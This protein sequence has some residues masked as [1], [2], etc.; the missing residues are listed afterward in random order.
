MKSPNYGNIS[1]WIAAI[2]CLILLVPTLAASD[3]N[4]ERY[5]LAQNIY[6]ESAN[7]PFAGTRSN[8]RDPARDQCEG[9][10]HPARVPKNGFA[11]A[12]SRCGGAGAECADCVGSGS[13]PLPDTTEI[14]DRAAHSS[15]SHRHPQRADHGFQRRAG[16]AEPHT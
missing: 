10:G 6:F 7:Q 8:C 14:L 13:Q 2:V 15:E 16:K 9:L 4:G 11:T 1:L 12:G 3:E 5:C